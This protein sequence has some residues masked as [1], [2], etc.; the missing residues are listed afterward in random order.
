MRWGLLPHSKKLRE[1]PWKKLYIQVL[2]RLV[3]I[4]VF[5]FFFFFQIM[6]SFI[7][8]SHRNKLVE[9]YFQL[10]CFSLQRDEKD[11]VELVRNCPSDQ[12]KEYYIQMQAAKRSQAPLPSQ[13]TPLI[14]HNQ[15]H[16]ETTHNIATNRF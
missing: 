7:R 4:L 1:C 10:V 16:E 14:L 11:M 3:L 9:S 12:F 2:N 6:I 8:L 5:K 15:F 13:V